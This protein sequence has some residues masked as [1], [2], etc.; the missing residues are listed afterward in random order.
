MYSKFYIFPIEGMTM[1]QHF[2]KFVNRIAV[3]F[4]LNSCRFLTWELS[5]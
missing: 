4:R 2:I 5:R 1:L 3:L